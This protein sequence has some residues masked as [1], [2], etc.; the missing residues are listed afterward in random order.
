MVFTEKI[1]KAIE[2]AVKTHE[3]D[4]KQ[5]RKIK[6][7]PYITHPMAVGL[8]LSLADSTEDTVAA[9]ILH[10]TIEDSIEGKKVTKEMITKEFGDN[11]SE[12]VMSVTELNKTLCWDERKKEA[13][14]HIKDFS[15]DSLLIKSADVI[16]NMSELVEDYKNNGDTVFSYFHAPKDK[17][18]QNQL[19]VISAISM[20]WAENPLLPDLLLLEKS[21]KEI[22]LK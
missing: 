9:G 20:E 14:G 15:H 11:V 10:D 3:I 12:L 7:I 8:I 13:L 16:S 19:N 17:I 18:I 1:Q 4:Q 6:D 5:R 21:L 2:L 22:S